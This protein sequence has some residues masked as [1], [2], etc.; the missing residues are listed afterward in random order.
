MAVRASQPA[1]QPSRW[2]GDTALRGRRAR[3]THTRKSKQTQWDFSQR[4]MHFPSEFYCSPCGRP[5]ARASCLSRAA[6]KWLARWQQKLANNW[7]PTSLE[8][9]A[10][11]AQNSIH[12][13]IGR[14]LE[15]IMMAPGRLIDARPPPLARPQA[16]RTSRPVGRQQWPISERDPLVPL[17]ERSLAR[18][19]IDLRRQWTRLVVEEAQARTRI[20]KV[21]PNWRPS[22]TLA[23]LPVSFRQLPGGRWRAAASGRPS[24]TRSA[25]CKWWARA[26]GWPTES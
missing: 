21:N 17:C 10:R 12:S 22:E 15:R 11:G 7:Q 4:S 23:R 5:L 1:S 16:S 3:A 24:C 20:S 9:L 18:R 8:S 6:N 19:P 13:S 25:L 26:N 14:R 2:A